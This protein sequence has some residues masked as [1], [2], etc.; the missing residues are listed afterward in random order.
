VTLEKLHQ[1]IMKGKQ[2]SFVQNIKEKRK[3]EDYMFKEFDKDPNMEN[4][5]KNATIGGKLG[6]REYFKAKYLY[7]KY[8]LTEPPVSSNYFIKEKGKIKQ[9]ESIPQEEN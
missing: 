4:D 6:V 2:L 9:T 3:A 7:D 1:E 5:Y 8:K